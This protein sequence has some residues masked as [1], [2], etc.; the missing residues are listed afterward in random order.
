MGHVFLLPILH[1]SIPELSEGL[2]MSLRYLCNYFVLILLYLGTQIQT[3]ELEILEWLNG[4]NVCSASLIK[5]LRVLVPP[6]LGGLPVIPVSESR[7]GISRAYCMASRTR[8]FGEVWVW[9]SNLAILGIHMLVHTH[10]HTTHTQNMGKGEGLQIWMYFPTALYTFKHYILSPEH[11]LSPFLHYV[12]TA[13]LEVL[14]PR[15]SCLVSQPSY[16]V[17]YFG[18]TRGIPDWNRLNSIKIKPL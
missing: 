3:L 16:T 13:L 9:L 6:G 5:K 17:C 1:S 7:A 14:S 10:A 12:T 8:C 2:H 18:P 4:W 15:S 11:C